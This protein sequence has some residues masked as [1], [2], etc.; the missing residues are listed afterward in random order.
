MSADLRAI[1]NR[2]I[3]AY[4]SEH[5]ALVGDVDDGGW[6]FT[7]KAEYLWRRDDDV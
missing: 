1:R 2:A 4:E 6:P 7:D 3:D 5:A